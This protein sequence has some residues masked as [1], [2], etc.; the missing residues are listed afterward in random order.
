[1]RNKKL[2]YFAIGFLLFAIIFAFA[3]QFLKNK[4][5]G[6]STTGLINSVFENIFPFK[7]IVD[8]KGNNLTEDLKVGQLEEGPEIE[9]RPTLLKITPLPVSGATLFDATREKIVYQETASG[10][11]P[12]TEKFIGRF[13]RYAEKSSGHIYEVPFDGF[14][15]SKITGTTIPGT[16]EVLFDNTANYAIFR[17]YDDTVGRIKSF[18]GQ[19]PTSSTEIGRVSGEYLDDDILS[20]S[21]SPKDA[22]IIFS[23]EEGVYTNIFTSDF[24]GKNKKQT[25]SSPFSEWLLDWPNENNFTITTKPSSYFAGFV[26][27]IDAKTNAI[28]KISGNVSG[29]TYKEGSDQNKGLLGS[30]GKDSLVLYLLNKETGGATNLSIGTLPEKCTFSSNSLVYCFV[31]NFLPSAV[32]PDDWYKG[33]VLFSDSLW[34]INLD[35]RAANK[36]VDISELAGEAIDGINL[37]LSDDNEDLI[38]INKKDLSLWLY[39]L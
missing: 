39:D 13:I 34:A 24:N 18:S 10:S 29:V 9:T 20:I 32:Y 16:E 5:G 30:A 21:F 2:F 12:V 31:P 17:Y 36:I 28:E 27:Q 25:F 38:F 23:K 19:I 14:V 37:S 35:S 26:Y 3:F 1:M 6:G 7:T 15:K 11:V 4:N 33:K 8:E 22:K